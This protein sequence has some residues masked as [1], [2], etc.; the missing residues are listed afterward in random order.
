MTT[1]LGIRV[2]AEDAEIAFARLEPVLAAGA[3]EVELDGLVEF[4]VYGDALPTDDEVRALAGD[5]VV[6]VV[7][8]RMDSGWALAWQDHL[9]PVTVGALTIRPPWIEGGVD[10]LVID[11][12]PSFGAASHPTTRLCLELLQETPPTA[13]ADW[14]AGSGVLAIAGARLGFA[15]VVAIE[16]DLLAAHVARR[17]AGR[18]GVT[19][20]VI[21]GDV[22]AAAP[23]APTIVANLTLPLLVAA[24]GGLAARAASSADAA[25]PTRPAAPSDATA[26]TRPAA[27]SDAA[28]SSPAGATRLIASGVLAS[29]A[30]EAVAAWAPLGFSERERRVLD[31][32][33]ALVLERDA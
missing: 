29:A 32:W 6:D 23:W 13:L 9:T 8:S 11:P 3:E 19:V 10:D 21:E 4:A 5:A 7:R 33:A 24:A 12:G 22:T 15:P 30:H 16:L 17:N 25:A 2:R 27:P 31:G 28:A 20:E 18:N 1:R 26:P 14:G